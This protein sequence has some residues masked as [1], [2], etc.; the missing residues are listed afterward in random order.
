MKIY[1]IGTGYTPIPAQV[2]AATESV[3]EELTKSFIKKNI[4]VQIIDI[5]TSHRAPNDLPII[6][7]KVPSIFTKSD[8]SLGI[9]HKVKRVVYSV[10]LAFKLKKILKE[11]KEKIVLHFHNQYNIFFFLKLVNKEL[12]NKAIIAYTNHN[13]YWSLP[14]DEAKSTLESRYFQEIEGMKNSD[15]IFALNQKTQSSVTENLV[16]PKDKVLVVAN[17]VNT[18]IYR[19]LD[20][21]RIEEVKE[22]YNIVGKKVILQVG[23]VYENKGQCR[24]VEMIAPLLKDNK[25][26]IF[27]FLGGIVSE[28]YYNQVEDIA[29]KNGVDKQVLYLGTASPGEEMNEIYNIA[30]A[31]LFVSQYEGFPLVCIESLSAGVPVII[32][33]KNLSGFG[34]GS[35]VTDDDCFNADVK[36]ILENQKALVS[37]KNSARENAVKNYTWSKIAEDYYDNFR[38][39]DDVNG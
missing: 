25:D 39:W 13:G 1:E 22:K 32:N 9:I 24:A 30:E 23:S 29:K 14:F 7:V 10:A 34:E 31:T 3:V 12:R 2:A 35:V 11:S 27:A 33:S 19:P 37:L 26:L 18:E 28:E 4:D 6:E 5:S 38:V 15:V 20:E 17:G 8:V 36:N 16:I 21:K